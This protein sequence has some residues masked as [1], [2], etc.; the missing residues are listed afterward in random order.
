M[1][2]N[3]TKEATTLLGK[4]QAHELQNLSSIKGGAST[5]TKQCYTEEST[6]DTDSS[7]DSDSGKEEIE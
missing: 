4:F 7:S 6:W 1:Y 3:A 2:T 5:L